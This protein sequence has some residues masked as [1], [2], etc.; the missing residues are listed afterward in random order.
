MRS[1]CYNGLD[2]EIT[3]E[4]SVLCTGDKVSR[5]RKQRSPLIGFEPIM[6]QTCKPLHHEA[7]I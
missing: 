6:S 4:V 7:L 5:A 1:I 2:C 3:L